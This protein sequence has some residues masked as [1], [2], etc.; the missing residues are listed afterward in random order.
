MAVRYSN[1]KLVFCERRVEGTLKIWAEPFTCLRAP[2]CSTC[3]WTLTNAPM[4][5]RTPINDW[6]IR[7]AFL[8]VRAQDLV[9]KFL[10]TFKEYPPRQGPSSFSVDQIIGKFMSATTVSS[11]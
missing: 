9:A 5:R 10:M 7:H 11:Q 8:L 4:S 3:V 1:W 6:M 2:K